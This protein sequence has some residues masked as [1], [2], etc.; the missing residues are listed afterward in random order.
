MS[1]EFVGIRVG[2][3][4]DKAALKSLRELQKL[5]KAVDK[6]TVSIKVNTSDLNKV[7]RKLNEI[8]KKISEIN[9]RSI[10]PKTN[11]SNI[12]KM[13][14]NLRTVGKEIT[15]NNKKSL[16]PRS[17]VSDIRRAEEAVKR[18]GRVINGVAKP[19]YTIKMNTGQVDRA[20]QATQ[21]VGREIDN[22]NGKTINPKV[23]THNIT[24]VGRALVNFGNTF[25][26]LAN[27]PFTNAFRQIGTS[28]IGQFTGLVTQGLQRTVTRFDTMK[29]YPMMME[30]MGFAADK[31]KA[32][33]DKL[34]ASVQGLPTGL[35][36]IVDAAKQYALTTGDIEKGTNYAIAANRAFLA[37]ASSESQQYQGRLQLNDLF[38]GKKLNS[39]EW[40]SLAA[41]MPAAIREIGKVLGYKDTGKFRQDLFANKVAAED[42]ANALVK[43]GTEGGSIYNL[44]E[45][46]KTT[47]SGLLSNLK[48][49]ISRLGTGV[50]DSLDEV[51]TKKTGKSLVMNL[52]ET[53]IPAIDS[54]TDRFKTWAKANPDKIIGFF[55]AIKNFDWAGL[56]R[57]IMEAAKTYAG[58]FKFITTY[59]PKGMLG[60]ILAGGTLPIG[61]A[62]SL[63]GSMI[64]GI[65]R[66]TTAVSKAGEAG[67]AA[68]KVG[69]FSRLFGRG[70]DAA[71]A[72]EGAA[73]TA[74]DTGKMSMSLK[75]IGKNFLNMVKNAGVILAY[76]GTVVLVVK[77]L[78]E[79]GKTKIDWSKTASNLGGSAAAMAGMTGFFS[80]LGG[81]AGQL[82]KV[83]AA[84]GKWAGFAKGASG[85][86]SIAASF[87]S[88]LDAKVFELVA[89][90]LEQLNK[91]DIGETGAVHKK[92]ALVAAAMAEMKAFSMLS[93]AVFYSGGYF[94]G[95]ILEMLGSFSQIVTAGSWL[96]V[97]KA[98]DRIS[99]L[100]VPSRGKMRKVARSLLDLKKELVSDEFLTGLSDLKKLNETR[101]VLS[102]LADST[103]SLSKAL[104]NVM[105]IQTNLQEIGKT[106]IEETTIN[107][108]ISNIESITGSFGGL[109]KAIREMAGVDEENAV[110]ESFWDA[111]GKSSMAE[112]TK[113]YADTLTQ[114]NIALGQVSQVG[115]K[116]FAI[117][118]TMAELKKKYSIGHGHN[119]EL[120]THSIQNE[121]TSAISLINGIVNGEN[122][123][124]SLG[125]AV[126]RMEDVD[127][128]NI[129]TQLDN[130]PKIIDK[131]NKLKEKLS[132][133]DWMKTSQK[134]T[135]IE[136]PGYRMG[137]AQGNPDSRAVMSKGYTA[138]ATGMIATIK[139]M[140]S[141]LTDIS[142]E[143]DKVAGLGINEKAVNLQ[144][145]IEG[146]NKAVGMMTKLRGTASKD[147][148]ASK[149][150]GAVN[151]A[152][153][154]RDTITKLSEAL[155]G[156]DTLNEKV[157]VF[158]TVLQGLK[159]AINN[160]TV[161]GGAELTGFYTTLGQMPGKLTAV[162]N[163]VRGKGKEWKEQIAGGFKGTA[164]RVRA[165]VLS[166][167]RVLA[168]LNFRGAGAQAGGT[169]AAGFNAAVRNISVP[170]VSA[171]RRSGGSG[172]ILGRIRGLFRHDGGPIT[173]KGANYLS[174]GGS[175]QAFP[176]RPKGIDRIPVWA[177]EGEYMLNRRA[178]SAI[179][180]K[181]LEAFNKGNWGLAFDR[182]SARMGSAAT[183]N[184]T[185]TVDRSHHTNI[186]NNQQVTQN[187]GRANQEFS[188][189]RMSKWLRRM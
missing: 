135:L 184:K 111:P 156:A 25:T 36:E 62:F 18:L 24:E 68:G 147:S 19:T 130:I 150:K 7:V 88:L 138:E 20:G 40:M 181:A 84:G 15:N 145:A 64:T 120:D 187:I 157:V 128:T 2:L 48:I 163:A 134:R 31:S 174:R 42:F 144:K 189:I 37:S 22:V 114:M 67:K 61:R 1:E 90:L 100:K 143:L 136:N 161:A 131:I 85:W 91:I 17:N 171:P 92:I 117:R 142:N 185:V 57:G 109:Y 101:D 153:Y 123:L 29:T 167:R 80:A 125:E 45:I 152:S 3:E 33:I 107:S 173:A 78:R 38:A 46:S 35:D 122:G 149:G 175:P 186:Y 27:N 12:Q 44:A 162:S 79:I 14:T 39:R 56:G 9:K 28:F 41:S 112:Q 73:S 63:F 16:R 82:S 49:A 65:G 106:K 94:L 121:I 76:T 183:M 115:G 139:S 89:K 51:F 180:E 34:D 126:K 119:R 71:E 11:S 160:L 105:A 26:N 140:V 116:I 83:G 43:V 53:I 110:G 6:T 141:M 98:L 58:V 103:K 87:T 8:N 95:G 146:V 70:K 176:G 164:A 177:A 47:L 77:A 188:E 102:S 81:I 72:A 10:N 113:R 165:E 96:E 5:V 182:L 21:R 13:V 154:I 170:N 66:L 137:G 155:S 93:G 108:A 124:G 69:F 127:V 133:E 158:Q 151:L 148:E 52:R 129:G 97:T 55:N 179:G 60:F 23:N 74:T 178:T 99:K 132:G 86:Y 32:S 168:N 104:S 118:K 172:G 159:T 4:G 50:L 54:I 75:D 30:A 59:M 166:I 169:Y